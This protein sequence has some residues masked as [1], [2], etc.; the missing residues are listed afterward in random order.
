MSEDDIKTN[1]VVL[2]PE[3]EITRLASLPDLEYATTRLDAARRLHMKAADLDRFVNAKRKAAGLGKENGPRGEKIDLKDPDPWGLPVDGAELLH[4]IISAIQRHATLEEH[5]ALAIALWVLH[6]HA[7]DMAEH[8]PRLHLSSPVKRCGKSV[9]LRMVESMVPRALS[10]EFVTT[11]ALF[12]VIEAEH[13]TM[14]IDEVDTFLKDNEELR[15]LLNAGHW[16]GGRVIKTV[17]VGDN[18]EPRGFKVWAATCIAGIGKI[19]STVADRSITITMRR[20]LRS[21][22]KE[23]LISTKRQHLECLCNQAARWIADNETTIRAQD[24]VIPEGLGDRAADNWRPL[25]AIAD[26]IGGEWAEAS[27]RAALTLSGFVEGDEDSY[28]VTLIRD[29][30]GLFLETGSE[31]INTADILEHLNGLE[32]RPWAEWSRG[33]NLNAN[34]LSRLLKPFG[35]TPRKRRL[36][37]SKPFR[38][39]EREDFR[40]A[41]DRYSDAPIDPASTCTDAQVGTVEQVMDYS[42]LGVSAAGTTSE[43]VPTQVSANPLSEN[44][45]SGV[46]GRGPDPEWEDCL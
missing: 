14:L 28:A 16:R 44:D 18:H 26:V 42:D 17:A 43:D 41:C 3:L 2:K 40:E 33:K 4:D 10:M 1:V 11:A 35:I 12:R 21:E 38:G 13:P 6:A 20:Q 15:G 5:S 39:Y 36:P 24:P 46:P 45:C 19:P 30:Y 9:V 37:G 29:I 27:R 7:L 32:E 25:L 31:R 8:S 22:R 34:G 23:R